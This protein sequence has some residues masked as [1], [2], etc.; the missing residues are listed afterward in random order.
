MSDMFCLNAL[1]ADEEPVPIVPM[2]PA[3]GSAGNAKDTEEGLG[4]GPEDRRAAEKA[5]KTKMLMLA[6][7]VDAELDVCAS[8]ADESWSWFWTEMEKLE[9]LLESAMQEGSDTK[10]KEAL[11]AAGRLRA[12]LE[13]A[14][15]LDEEGGLDG[16]TLE[17]RLFNHFLVVHYGTKAPLEMPRLPRSGGPDVRTRSAAAAEAVLCVD[18]QS[19]GMILAREP[20]MDRR[21]PEAEPQPQL[22]EAP[23]FTAPPWDRRRQPGCKGDGRS[24]TGSDMSEADTVLQVVNTRHVA[25]LQYIYQC[26]QLN[27]PVA[28]GQEGLQR[29]RK[30]ACSYLSPFGMVHP[31][32]RYMDTH[33]PVRVG[34]GYR[35][36]QDRPPPI[37]CS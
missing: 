18:V 34:G 10:A 28:C 20:E 7:K 19:H 6:D 1:P 27:M 30:V 29:T 14:Q 33:R 37:V 12:A 9:D 4:R 21:Q 8:L 11:H 5:T 15:A 32:F 2:V 23:V 17:D 16:Q 13:K 22:V 26:L 25:S 3:R 36:P 24:L 31:V 35:P